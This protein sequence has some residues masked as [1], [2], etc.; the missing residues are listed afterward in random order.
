MKLRILIALLACF[1]CKNETALPKLPTDPKD[2]S[3][4]TMEERMDMVSVGNPSPNG[5]LT[6][7]NEA[8]ID[9]D[10]FKGKLVVI[11]FWATWCAPCLQEA[12]LF[13]EIAE[14]Y[15]NSN[16]EFIS[17][18]IDQEFADWK[19]YISKNNWTGKNYWFGMQEEAPFFSYLFSKTM[20]KSNEMI[21]IG[22]PKYVIIS[23]EGI[24]V[25][26]SDLRP[27]KPGFEIEIQKQLN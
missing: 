19:S 26:N 6:D 3:A 5:K 25:S 15:K 9:I 16:A 23:P 8:I 10:S 11:D 22:I 14:K 13:K 7:P 2:V 17:I 27:S 4:L 1:S 24:I 12:P 21:L 18:S 20:V